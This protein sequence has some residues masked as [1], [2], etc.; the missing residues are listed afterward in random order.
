MLHVCCRL[1]SEMEKCCF[2]NRKAKALAKTFAFETTFL[3]YSATTMKTSTYTVY[4][5]PQQQN[6]PDEHEMNNLIN[7]ILSTLLPSNFKKTED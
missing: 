4:S 3:H 7:E 2:L 1:A 5:L 6:R